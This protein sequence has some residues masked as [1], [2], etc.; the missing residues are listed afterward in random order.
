MFGAK[1][2]VFLAMVCTLSSSSAF[3]LSLTYSSATNGEVLLSFR[4]TIN[5][6]NWTGI[7][8]EG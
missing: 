4:I 8:S 1:S 5:N 6:Y 7:L 3:I 2:A